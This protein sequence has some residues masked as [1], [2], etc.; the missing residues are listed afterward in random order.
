MCQLM[1]VLPSYS[2]WR[3]YTPVRSPRGIFLL[4]LWP[5]RHRL[6]DRNHLSMKA[7]G[8]RCSASLYPKKVLVFRI[9]LSYVTFAKWMPCAISLKDRVLSRGVKDSDSSKMSKRVVTLVL[10]ISR[11]WIHHFAV[12]PG[13]FD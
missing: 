13:M 11:A 9:H 3:W 12:S 6:P 5:A 4:S 8:F 1:S 7:A 2:L 10:A